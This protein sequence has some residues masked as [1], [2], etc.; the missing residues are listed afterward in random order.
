MRRIRFALVLGVVLIAVAVMAASQKPAQKLA[1][2][3]VSIKPV[4]PFQIRPGIRISGNRFDC[5]MPLQRLITTAY[6]I[7]TYQI[8]G[9]DWLNSQRYEINPTIPE[10]SSKD[11]VPGMLQALLEDRF[12]L[13]AH[14]EKKHQPVYALI[15]PK[16]REPEVDESRRDSL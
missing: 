8:T 5:A 16:K 14:L 13:K 1:F 7:K 2:E 11:Q 4:E 3:V 12:K 10:G 15:V 9:P 6:Q